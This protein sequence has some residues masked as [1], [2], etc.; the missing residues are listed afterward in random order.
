MPQTPGKTASL[1]QRHMACCTLWRG[2]H[3]LVVRLWRATRTFDRMRGLLGLHALAPGEGL[4]L[5]PC[6]A[7]HTIGMRFAID[8][9]FIDRQWVV[10]RVKVGARP[11]LWMV[12]GGVG[13]RRTIEVAAGWLE[14]AGLEGCQ[15][16][17][18]PGDGTAIFQPAGAAAKARPDSG[19]QS[20]GC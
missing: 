15:L 9:L 4:L 10:R 2:Q 14:V 12:S 16:A 18:R 17:L 1:A 7:V 3:P 20:P 5:D 13:V 6:A 8:V 11:G 19:R